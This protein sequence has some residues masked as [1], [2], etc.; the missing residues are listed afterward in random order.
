MKLNDLTQSQRNAIFAFGQ[1]DRY[2]TVC[3]LEGAS[4]LMEHEEK[5]EE[6]HRLATWIL[7]GDFSD[8]YWTELYHMIKHQKEIALTQAMTEW[9]KKFGYEEITQPWSENARNRLIEAIASPSCRLTYLRLKLAQYLATDPMVRDIIQKTILELR[10]HNSAE[11][12]NH[13]FYKSIE[14]V[15]IGGLPFLPSETQMVSEMLD[16]L[17]S[18]SPASAYFPLVSRSVW[19]TSTGAAVTF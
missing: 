4:A 15:N 10:D 5:T 13:R 12:K 19:L 8:E 17:I 16:E 9:H 14:Q 1:A 18:D 11:Y 6:L 2:G 7:F 3:H